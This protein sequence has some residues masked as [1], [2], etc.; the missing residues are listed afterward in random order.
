MPIEQTLKVSESAREARPQR[1]RPVTLAGTAE[2][3]PVDLT[4][5]FLRTREVA[6]DP[7]T[8]RKAHLL[9]PDL[10]T[11]P[12]QSFRMLRTQVLQRLRA[13]GWNSLAVV[14]ATPDE[15]K[16][17]VA[18]NLAMAISMDVSHNALLVE[19]DLRR[20]SLARRL[21]IDVTVGVEEVLRGGHRVEAAMVRLTGYDRLLLLPAAAPVLQSSELLAG[22]PAQE[23]AAELKARYADRIVIFDLPPLLGADDAI[24][25]LPCVDAV[26]LV[27]AEGHTKAAHLQR[28]V[29]LLRDKPILGTVLNR[30]RGMA[31]EYFQY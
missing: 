6:V 29:E 7:E 17:T 20:P 1:E 24:A 30:S 31:E 9:R 23:L 25:F 27:V 16:S 3:R 5:R 22:P 26:L 10:Q 2:P 11:A 15:G 18:V 8:L 19:F 28:A 4:G 13:N 12:A 14:G 21:G